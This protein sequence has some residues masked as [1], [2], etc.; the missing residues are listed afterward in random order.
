[1]LE[2]FLPSRTLW[3]FE[4]LF[5]KTFR[6]SNNESLI[7]NK[8]IEWLNSQ[9]IQNLEYKTDR[10]GNLLIKRT[11]STKHP[12]DSIIL[13]AHMDMVCETDLKE[14]NFKEQSIPIRVSADGKWIETEGTTLGADN[15]IGAS[16]CLDIITDPDFESFQRDLFVLLTVAEESGLDGAFQ[17]DPEYFGLSQQRYLINVDSESYGTIIIGSAGGNSVEIEFENQRDPTQNIPKQNLGDFDL[18]LLKIEGLKGGHSGTDIHL[19]RANAIKLSSRILLSMIQYADIR[20]VSWNGGN[21]T[22][23]IP[24]ACSVSFLIEKAK[25]KEIKEIITTQINEI[26]T[27]YLKYEPDLKITFETINSADKLESFPLDLSRQIIQAVGIIPSGPIVFSPEI[28]GFVETSNNLGIISTESGKVKIRNMP[29]SS[30]DA[31]LK[32]WCKVIA[33]CGS[34]N[35]GKASIGTGYSGWIPN[36]ENP[37]LKKILPFYNAQYRMDIENKVVSSTEEDKVKYVAIHAGL[38]CG[39]ISSKIEGL[40][41]ISIGP[42]IQ[43]LHSPS[44]RVFIPSVESL[45]KIIK[46]F[47]RDDL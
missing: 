3:I 39:I 16:L 25:I 36:P 13:Q 26:E 43:N 21:K 8:I 9:K 23:A 45:H 44:E 41:C 14:F 19:P 2:N 18:I 33:A 27:S 38:E 28:Q 32:Y 11:S 30:K 24:R 17:L 37:L 46:S 12:R 31:E 47:L 7:R 29:R 15:G 20:L 34:S 40:H 5:T 4:H 6:A 42:T 10:V 1:M 35:G 22:N